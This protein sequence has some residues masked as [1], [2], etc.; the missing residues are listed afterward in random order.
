MYWRKPPWGKKWELREEA[1]KLPRGRKGE[2]KGGWSESHTIVLLPSAAAS[3]KWIY[4][5]KKAIRVG[6]SLTF[7]GQPPWS[8]V[9]THLNSEDISGAVHQWLC[10]QHFHVQVQAHILNVSYFWLAHDGWEPYRLLYH[11][12]RWQWS[13]KQIK[14]HKVQTKLSITL[15]SPTNEQGLSFVP[16]DCWIGKYELDFQNTQRPGKPFLTLL[17]VLLINV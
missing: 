15:G 11:M 3:P 17:C 10:P 12:L 7:M 2:G 4:K 6:Q 16:Y 14:C 1:E 5:P 8:C 13:M 9:D